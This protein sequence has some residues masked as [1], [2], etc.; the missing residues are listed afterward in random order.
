MTMFAWTGCYYHLHDFGVD[1]KH[2]ASGTLGMLMAWILSSFF[3]SV[4]NFLCY[5][6][7]LLIEYCIEQRGKL[8]VSKNEMAEAQ[9]KRELLGKVFASWR[10]HVHG[11]RA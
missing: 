4:Y 11:G 2:D 10:D 3:S 5:H 6:R 1:F 8:E 9:E 7:L